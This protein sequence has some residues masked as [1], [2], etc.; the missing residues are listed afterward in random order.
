[1]AM[2][3]ARLAA[4]YRLRGADAVYAAVAQRA[5]ATLITADR[6]QLERLEG[7]VPILSPVQALR[8]FADHSETACTDVPG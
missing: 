3:S 4:H 6:Q 2:L 5:E 8:E 1:M 7:A